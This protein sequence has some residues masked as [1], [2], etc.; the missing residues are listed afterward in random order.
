[1]NVGTEI[2]W[3]R[4]ELPDGEGVVVEV[5]DT[6]MHMVRDT[7]GNLHGFPEHQVD[8]L[9]KAKNAESLQD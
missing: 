5:K 8:D 2:R 7:H 1:M 4:G 3:D 6:G 9:L